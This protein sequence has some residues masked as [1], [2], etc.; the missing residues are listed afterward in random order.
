MDALRWNER[1][2]LRRPVLIAAFE[3]W[4][5]SSDAASTAVGYLAEAWSAPP[6]ASI[7]S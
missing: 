2:S 4:N 7:D 3:S 5:D 6:F 1:P